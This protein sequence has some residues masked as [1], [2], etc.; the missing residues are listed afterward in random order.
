MQQLVTIVTTVLHLGNRSWAVVGRLEG[1]FTATTRYTRTP[2]FLHISERHVFPCVFSLHFKCSCFPHLFPS[3]PRLCFYI[4]PLSIHTFSSSSCLYLLLYPHLFV[5]SLP[6][7]LISFSTLL[8]SFTF[9][10]PHSLTEPLSSSRFSSFSTLLSSL[11]DIQPCS[12]PL[13]GNW[14]SLPVTERLICPWQRLPHARRW[15][16]TWRTTHVLLLCHFARTGTNIWLD[17]CNA[18]EL[19]Y[20]LTIAQRPLLVES[21]KLNTTITLP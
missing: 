1:L 8:T 14:L 9:C 3:S 18:S 13:S 16:F 19:L 2:I 12:C 7:L 21:L 10:L 11:G 15:I 4:L 5:L 17:Y 6:I 20:G